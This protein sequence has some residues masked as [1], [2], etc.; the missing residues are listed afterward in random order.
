MR[1]R[2]DKVVGD[3]RSENYLRYDQGS[4]NLEPLR[5]DYQGDLLPSE[6]TVN[7]KF[8]TCAWARSISYLERCLGKIGKKQDENKYHLAFEQG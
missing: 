3:E 7:S 6:L 4:S 5:A 8:T 2:V 1:S